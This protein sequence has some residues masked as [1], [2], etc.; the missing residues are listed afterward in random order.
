MKDLKSNGFAKI[1]WYLEYIR[2]RFNPDLSEMPD[3]SCPV[4][5]SRPVDK[6]CSSLKYR[7]GKSPRDFCFVLHTNRKD[8][9]AQHRKSWKTMTVDEARKL[10]QVEAE[11]VDAYMIVQTGLHACSVCRKSTN[12]TWNW[13]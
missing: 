4:D 12:G 6:P 8:P 7:F 2:S 13:F 11:M 9:R 10:A 5:E 1:K 3:N